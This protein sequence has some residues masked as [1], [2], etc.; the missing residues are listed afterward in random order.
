[1]T[2]PFT[3]ANDRIF[4]ACQALLYGN[5]GA[6]ASTYLEGVQ[7]VGIDR[8]LAPESLP[9]PGRMMQTWVRYGK[10]T[11]TINVSRLLPQDGTTFLVSGGSNYVNGHLWS[12][13]TIGVN[14]ALKSWDLKL[15]YSADSAENVGD[16]ATY[17]TKEY[18]YCLLTNISYNI[19]VKGGVV[20]TLTFQS[21]IYNQGESS[22]ALSLPISGQTIKRQDI[23]TANCTFPKEVNEAFD[24]GNTEAGIPIFGLQSIDLSCDIVYRDLTDVGKWRGSDNASEVNRWKVPEVPAQ[25][26]ANFNGLVRSNYFVNSANQNHTVTDT[27][28]TAGTYGS[29]TKGIQNYAVD[30][31]IKIVTNVLSG[32]N[33]F[34]WDLS[35]HNY[36][37]SF[38]VTG[39]DAGTSDN[40]QATLGFTNDCSDF[41]LYQAATAANFNTS[42]IY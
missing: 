8:N 34:Q 31:E 4:Y 14:N 33:L 25:I 1:M 12:T 29:E 6:G 18:K 23:D 10:T 27:Y 28:H 13:N 15:V 26:S 30:R 19:P 32:S 9:D 41:F 36:L 22:A 35:N 40:V 16:V 37:T 2:N 21:E 7:S 20:E 3:P 39:G 42:T 5:G 11:Y 38:N 24:I 17:S